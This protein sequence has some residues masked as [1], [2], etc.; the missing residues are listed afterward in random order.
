MNLNRFVLAMIFP[1][2]VPP[3]RVRLVA[4]SAKRPVVTLAD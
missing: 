2:A 1:V 3:Q 4:Q